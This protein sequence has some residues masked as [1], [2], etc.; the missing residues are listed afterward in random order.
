MESNDQLQVPLRIQAEA[1]I[2]PDI[3]FADWLKSFVGWLWI[4]V[5]KLG[6][7]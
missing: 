7:L 5:H 4:A 2:E 6:Q 3:Q 1:L